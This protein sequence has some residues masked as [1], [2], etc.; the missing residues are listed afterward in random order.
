MK[1][2]IT[3]TFC[4]CNSVAKKFFTN[5]IIFHRFIS[6]QCLSIIISKLN[7]YI[8][9]TSYLSDDVIN[10]RNQNHGTHK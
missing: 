7:S 1:L 8:I 6:Y 10:S 3:F 2:K 5:Y 4:S 9:N